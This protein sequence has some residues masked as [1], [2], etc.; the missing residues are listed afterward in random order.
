MVEPDDTTFA[1]APNVPVSQS[2]HPL[3][4]PL[5]TRQEKCPRRRVVS[6]TQAPISCPNIFFHPGCRMI[7]IPP[8]LAFPGNPPGNM[9]SFPGPRSYQNMVSQHQ[10]IFLNLSHSVWNNPTV[11]TK[12]STR[13]AV[14]TFPTLLRGE[15]CVGKMFLQSSMSA[16]ILSVTAQTKIP[17]TPEEHATNFSTEYSKPIQSPKY[18]RSPFPFLCKILEHEKKWI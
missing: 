13:D 12:S 2:P 5:N 18:L 9:V 8:P 17:V 15:G 11:R 4:R 3:M 1:G 7:N 16:L 14:M 10:Y 6:I